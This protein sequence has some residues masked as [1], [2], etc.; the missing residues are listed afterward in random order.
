M[1]SQVDISKGYK[2]SG[3]LNCAGKEVFF[4]VL[5]TESLGGLCFDVIAWIC[6][7]ISLILHKENAKAI[8]HTKAY[9][10]K[11]IN[12]ALVV[13]SMVTWFQSF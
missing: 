8:Q 12:I 9:D 11:P 1:L 13:C 3:G 7:D 6:M 5:Q 4:L 10:T 2:A